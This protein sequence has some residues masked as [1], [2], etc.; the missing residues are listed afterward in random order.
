MHVYCLIEPWSVSQKFFLHVVFP[1]GQ[2]EMRQ[3]G[4]VWRPSQSSCRQ[5]W[6]YPISRCG[7]TWTFPLCFL[8]FLLFFS[9]L[10]LIGVESHVDRPTTCFSQLVWGHFSLKN[11]RL[12]CLSPLRAF[13]TQPGP[14]DWITVKQLD[15]PGAEQCWFLWVGRLRH[16]P[17]VG[18]VR[19]TSALSFTCEKKRGSNGWSLQGG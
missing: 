13:Y 19:H 8:F 12:Q 17:P 16:V 9:Q 14:V 10:K 3:L 4:I 1:F 2:T 18:G 11:T 5:H 7:T 15:N 6:V